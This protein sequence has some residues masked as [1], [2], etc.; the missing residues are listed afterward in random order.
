MSGDRLLGVPPR[1]RAE[2][3]GVGGVGADGGRKDL[4]PGP[5]RLAL[6]VASVVLLLVTLALLHGGLYTAVAGSN[7]AGG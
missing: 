5:W 1:A 3:A 4:M 6:L 7:Q 2:G